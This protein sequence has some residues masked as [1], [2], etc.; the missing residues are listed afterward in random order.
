[1]ATKQI[2]QK[3]G[4]KIMALNVNNKFK[5]QLEVKW[6]LAIFLV[7]S[8]TILIL[9][10]LFPMIMNEIYSRIAESSSEAVGLQLSNLLS[11]AGAAPYEIKMYYNPSDN[12]LYDLYSENGKLKVK[13]KFSVSY[14]QS[15][16]YETKYCTNFND[17]SFTDVNLFEIEKSLDN[18]GNSVY[19][20]SAK[21][22]VK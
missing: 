19:K 10:K 9:T 17:F 11:I 6:F 18:F 3:N 2:L 15:L 14:I 21:K 13:A 5:S 20:I 8:V 16:T 1:M 12:V 7:I 4:V 22:A